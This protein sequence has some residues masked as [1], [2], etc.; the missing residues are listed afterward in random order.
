LL[1]L[2]EI[3]DEAAEKLLFCLLDRLRSFNPMSLT[4][5]ANELKV[6]VFE[7]HKRQTPYQ[8]LR[9]SLMTA[10]DN[11]IQLQTKIDEYDNDYTENI[12]SQFLLVERKLVKNVKGFWK[13]VNGA[14][15]EPRDRYPGLV[16]RL[17]KEE[18]LLAKLF[19][20]FETKVVDQIFKILEDRW[21]DIELQCNSIIKE[22]EPVLRE[23]P[24]TRLS[25]S[26]TPAKNF[27]NEVI[28]Q[29]ILLVNGK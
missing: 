13:L 12:T 7:L 21:V 16:S 20:R 29:A 24:L 5:G 17:I 1:L 25:C 19:E 4:I 28:D 3:E 27:Q 14:S 2:E 6:N 15:S 23:V 8:L 26:S 11:F 9:R 22:L 10:L 18:R